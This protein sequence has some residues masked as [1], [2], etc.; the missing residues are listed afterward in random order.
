ME[1]NDLGVTYKTETG[2]KRFPNLSTVIMVENILESAEK[3][4]TVAELKKLLPK[5]I[6]HQTLLVIVDYLHKSGKVVIGV[7]GILWVFTP[8]QEIEKMLNDG[9]EL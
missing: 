2:V 5:M 9:T 7:K 1:L 6:M 8:R 3:V 4:L